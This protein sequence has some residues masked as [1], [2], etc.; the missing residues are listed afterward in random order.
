MVEAVIGSRPVDITKEDGKIRIV[1]HPVAKWVKHPKA[2][3]FSIKL[4]RS[5]METL[6]D[7]F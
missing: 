2:N 3:V 4:S 1:F 5:D 7:A 6:N